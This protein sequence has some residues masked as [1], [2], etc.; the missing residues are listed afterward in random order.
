[1]PQIQYNTLNNHCRKLQSYSIINLFHYL[2]TTSHWPF[3]V[4]SANTWQRY[5][6]LLLL[7]TSGLCPLHYFIC[8][9][10]RSS[11]WLIQEAL[12]LLCSLSQLAPIAFSAIS[13][14][15]L[16]GFPSLEYIIMHILPEWKY[17]CDRCHKSPW[18]HHPVIKTWFVTWYF[19]IILLTMWLPIKW[20]HPCD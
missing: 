14:L 6:L 20:N 3:T 5:D 1:M 17:Q 18:C 13:I 7:F 4:L 8:N 10:L 11:L 19:N 16:I 15:S 12:S 2:P 9:W